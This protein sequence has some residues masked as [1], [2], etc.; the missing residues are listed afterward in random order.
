MGT[1]P[2]DWLGITSLSLKWPVLCWVGCETDSLL[3]VF[4]DEDDSESSAGEESKE[5]VSQF[6]LQSIHNC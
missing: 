1:K 4:S 5:N 2:T 3:C 6:P